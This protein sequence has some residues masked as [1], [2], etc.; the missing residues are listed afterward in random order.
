LEGINTLY[1]Y[2]AYLVYEL[3]K[4]ITNGLESDRSKFVYTSSRTLMLLYPTIA[5]YCLLNNI[6]RDVWWY[7]TIVWWIPIYCIAILGNKIEYMGLGFSLSIFMSEFYE[8]PYYIYRIL[9]NRLN[10]F[11]PLIV[12]PKLMFVLI[13]LKIM[14]E[15]GLDTRG[16]IKELLLYMSAYIPM[17]VIGLYK[18]SGIYPSIV[19]LH[20]AK[21][22]TITQVYIMVRRR[23][24]NVYK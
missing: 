6:G 23:V 16:F 10:P 18:I 5:I 9:H 22:A 14:K 15:I 13:S 11:V 4:N 2:V 21:T 24:K 1:Y 19:W 20:V 7:A 3:A 17:I 8:I 12:I